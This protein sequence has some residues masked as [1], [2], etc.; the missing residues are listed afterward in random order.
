MIPLHPAKPNT[1]SRLLRHRRRLLKRLLNLRYLPHTR[2]PSAQLEYIRLVR[3]RL[4]FEA[5]STIDEHTYRTNHIHSH[6]TILTLQ[7]RH[8]IIPQPILW[9][10]SPDRPPQNLSS[11]PL[12][13]HPIHC[14][15]LQTPRPR[16][17][18]VVQLLKS[19]L[20]R[21]VD[22]GAI[23]G[24]DVVATVGGRIIDG[25]VFTHE[26][27][28]DLGG[29]AAEGTGRRGEVEEVPAAGIG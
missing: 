8:P 3:M 16:R 4:S 19:L 12:S 24:N 6:R 21:R 1:R 15:T 25:F 28:G 11:T 18:L 29:E 9:Q 20:S 22:V 13:D 14:N 5:Y 27:D 7:P 23:D 10:H 2:G 17:L 26:A